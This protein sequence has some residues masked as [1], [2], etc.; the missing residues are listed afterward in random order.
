LVN[1]EHLGVF[2][3]ETNLTF[4]LTRICPNCTQSSETVRHGVGTRFGVGEVHAGFG[5]QS[6]C[7]FGV[8]RSQRLLRFLEIDVGL[9]DM[10]ST[11]TAATAS[12]RCSEAVTTDGYSR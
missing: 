9:I 8:S 2:Q 1:S 7:M 6:E 4:L 5:H 10:R 12:S 3:P 11:A